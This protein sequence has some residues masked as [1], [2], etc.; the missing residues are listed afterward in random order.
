MGERIIRATDQRFFFGAMEGC[1]FAQSGPERRTCDFCGARF[2]DHGLGLWLMGAKWGAAY[3]GMM[4]GACLTASPKRL[5]ELAR[6]R[7]PILRKRRPDRGDD[8]NYNIERAD[9][10]LRLAALFDTLD[11]IDAIDGGTLARKIGEAY[12]ELDAPRGG[13]KGAAA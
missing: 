3:G 13:Q 7:A 4:C 8:R 2:N 6:E 9:D 12:R 10:M 1:N 5:A 11:S